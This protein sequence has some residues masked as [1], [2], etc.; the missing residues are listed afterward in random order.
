MTATIV[1]LGELMMRLSP[2]RKLR[3]R[4]A[5]CFDVCHGGAEA[6]VAVSLANFG[7]VARF[8]SALPDTELGTQALMTLQAQGVDA[9]FVSRSDGRMG[10]YFME[11]GADYRAGCVIY[12]RADSA[13]THLD[14]ASVDW[15]AVFDGADMFHLS[16]ITPAI[17]AATRRLAERSVAE[18]RSSGVPVSIDLNYRERL[19][20]YGVAPCDVLPALVEQADT[21]IAGRGDCP[22][23]LGIDGDGENGS[24]EWA[25]SLGVKLTDRFPNLANIAITIRSSTT[26]EH[27]EWKAFLRRGDN[28][29][30]SRAY[31]MHGV[32]DRVGTGD[33]FS[34][35]LI[36]GL[37]QHQDAQEVVDFAAAANC[38]KHAIRGDANC[39]TVDEVKALASATSFGRLRR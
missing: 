17:C 15:D 10:L 1:T 25:H 29:V 22:A 7:V 18:A 24:D 6:N 36:Y 28:A 37:V 39:V 21:L 14:A 38:L 35:G 31:D 11:E 9:R 5:T 33:A 12:D 2:P 3:L 34:A 13:F 16:G 30:F 20:T 4:Q 32:I 27:H 19:W 8:V 23:C 26:A